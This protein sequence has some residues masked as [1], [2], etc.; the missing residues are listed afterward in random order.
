M[1]QQPVCSYCFIS[2]T[3]GRSTLLETMQRQYIS[4]IHVN[5][6]HWQPGRADVIANAL[7]LTWGTSTCS[8]LP[9]WNGFPSR[10][11]K[12]VWKQVP[13]KKYLGI[14]EYPK[15]R[16]IFQI[17]KTDPCCFGRMIKF[18]LKTMFVIRT[19]SASIFFS[20]WYSCHLMNRLSRN[21]VHIVHP[22]IQAALLTA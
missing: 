21:T 9:S 15:G 6:Y 1:Q 18:F 3:C 11:P 19:K 8:W 12:A 14:P 17:S 13:L 5:V 2:S 22:S 10:L 20:L 16:D 4:N 7:T